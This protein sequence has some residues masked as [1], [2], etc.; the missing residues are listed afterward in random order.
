MDFSDIALILVTSCVFGILVRWFKQ[1]LLVGYLFAGLFLGWIR[2]LPDLQGLK[3]LAQIGVALLLFLLGLEMNLK[4]L[5]SIG[6]A[7]VLTGVGQI[8]ITAI[9]G[10]F[11]SLSL[12]FGI[13][14][15][16]YIAIALTFSSTIIIVKLLS[17]K[18]D[19]RSLYGRI[20]IGFLLV[21]DFVA[22]II[23]ILLSGIGRGLN[24]F[25]DY[26]L[27]A[28]KG[29]FLFASVLAFSKGILRFIFERIA[30]DSQE[31]L[32][33]L[34]IAWALGFASFVY[35]VLGF[36]IEI[37]GFLAGLSLSN[38]PE[39][40]QISAKTKPLRDFF[41]SI[42]FVVLGTS[43]AVSK[44]AFRLFPKVVLL[45]AFVLLG[46]PIIVLV[47]MGLI[48]YKKRTSFL[49]GLTVAQISEFSLILVSVGKTLGHVGQEE[50][51][52]VTFVGIITITLST[53]MILASDKIYI[54]IKNYLSIF[55]RGKTIE[56][57]FS[58]NIQLKDHVVLVGCDRTGDSILR[59]LK[60]QKLMFVVVDFN[61]KVF[62]VLS[63]E[64]TPIVFGDIN[65]SET[66][67]AAN[68]EKAKMI[69]STINN[70][71]DNLTLLEY[72]R[73][74]KDKPVSIFTSGSKSEAIKLYEAG[75][76]YVIVP[77]M[78]AG[79]HIKHL[80]KTY[81]ISPTKLTKVGLK[82]FNRLIFSR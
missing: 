26:F 4:E 61:P 33:L 69:I 29:I 30:S 45:S 82:H 66:L 77:E 39:H 20:A 1:P 43:L 42:F 65:D 59:Y 60:A 12:G 21:Q 78:V 41:L 6:K 8:I 53:Y 16:V 70:A 52:L 40:L 54:K 81:N 64:K 28:F 63:A 23:L 57:A 80:L 50:V 72:L 9:I 27:V 49:A 48:G 76:T 14:A 74:L 19:L 46:N 68:V 73:G 35:K 62:S 58:G 5:P 3:S 55:E 44:E 7:A 13:L 38:L 31:L 2:I 67:S 10:F 34:S 32:F 36:T 71:S 17:E 11:I 25:Y 47:I 24:N 75:A 56:D 22:I 37:G 18:K 51:V 15:S 79:E